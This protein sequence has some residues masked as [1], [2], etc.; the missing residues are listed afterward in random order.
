MK[1]FLSLILSLALLLYNSGCADKTPVPQP[2][3]NI[4]TTVDFS[5]LFDGINGC[6][7]FYDPVILKYSFYNEQMCNE[8]YSP[9][10]TFKIIGV[11]EGLKQ[12]VIASEQSTMNYSGEV[13]PFESWNKNL[14]LYEAFQSSC[15]WYF[16]QVIDS[17]GQ[18]NIQNALS[19]LNYGNCDVS[20]WQGSGLNP[21]ADTN[22]FWLGSSLKIS[23]KE[24]IKVV[25]DIFEEKTDYTQDEI[26][27]L[28][29]VMVSDKEGV[30]GKTGTGRD[31][32][33]WYVGFYETDNHKI[34]FAVYL[35]DDTVENIAGATAKEITNKIID[36]YYR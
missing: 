23:P 25:S 18:E 30:Y 31:S 11:L 5:N 15:V 20:Q 13:Y 6:A 21:T 28:K 17:I 4:Y 9:Y 10:S 27:I 12:G 22:G 36:K 35:Q 7:V 19:S 29:N 8:R 33:A 14:N 24:Q 32:S 3:K 34:Y 2:A 1:K 26:T 16:R